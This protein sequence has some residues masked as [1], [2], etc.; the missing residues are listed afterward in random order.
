MMDMRATIHYILASA[1]RPVIWVSGGK[2]SLALLHMCQPWRHRLCVMHTVVDDTWPG[3]RDNLE[4][5][6]NDWGFLRSI[7]TVPLTDFQTFVREAGWPVEVTPQRYDGRHLSPQ[8]Q[9]SDPRMVSW[10]LC[11][12]TRCIMPLVHATNS[13]NAD[14]VLTGTLGRT[15]ALGADMP[16]DRTRGLKFRGVYNW[17]RYAPTDEWTDEQVYAYIDQHAIPLPPHYTIKRRRMDYR[18][19]ECLSCTWQPEHWQMLK[20]HYPE[21]YA[22][23]WPQVAPV[24]AALKEEMARL[25]T[26]IS[27]SE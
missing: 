9:F 22:K 3:L 15:G 12:L 26:R 8:R 14:V 10:W 20:A 16:V 5:C 1:Q 6:L 2:D 19:P 27:S 21:E 17:V 4:Q 18:W 24:F 13:Y 11:T 23:R 25:Q 7:F